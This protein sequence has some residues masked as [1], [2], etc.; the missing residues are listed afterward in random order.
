MS[1]SRRP[2]R[3]G[4]GVGERRGGRSLRGFAGAE[5]GLAGPVDHVHLDRPG[6]AGKRRIG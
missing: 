5:E 3:I 4:D 1:R 2:Q 6:T